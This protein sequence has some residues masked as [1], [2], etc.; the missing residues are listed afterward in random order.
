MELTL[1]ARLRTFS[2]DVWL[3]LGLLLLLIIALVASVL[4]DTQSEE[5]VL[6]SFSSA[7]NGTQALY[8]WLQALNQPVSNVVLASFHLPEDAGTT[9]MLQPTTPVLEQEWELLDKWVADGGTLLIAGDSTAAILAFNHY[10]FEIELLTTDDLH[11]VLHTPLFASPPLTEMPAQLLTSSYFM[12][13]RNDFVTHLTINN[14]PVL[15]SFAQEA[16]LVILTSS[17]VPFTNADLKNAGNPELILN[18][19][20]ARNRQATI[21]F[22]E[23][24][25][26]IRSQASIGSG[27][28]NWLRYHP[29]GRAF[30]YSASVILLA[31]FLSG[32]RLGPPV[33]LTY[34]I[35]RRAPLEYITG[36]AN[37]SRRAGHRYAVQQEYRQKLKR[38]LGFRYRLD[39]TLPDDEYLRQLATYNP[40]L[41]LKKIAN[42][43]KRLQNP[44]ITEQELV[45]LANQVFDSL[46]RGK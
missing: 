27:P 35:N 5:P 30:L 15:V 33:P 26:G 12:P 43:L 24:H 40:S 6:S 32:R 46:N 25:H 1:L 38:D 39:P 11:P 23:W 2:R 16:G 37:L 21:W 10:D 9:L 8:L 45:S 22:D 28:I 31:L 29:I 17:A 14:H 42:L 4:Q 44:Q 13:K 3:A 20:A 41:D 34:E 7:A 19:L 36:M 18:L